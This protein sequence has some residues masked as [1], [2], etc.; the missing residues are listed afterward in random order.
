MKTKTKLIQAFNIQMLHL[1]R[2]NKQ[3]ILFYKWPRLNFNTKNY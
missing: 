1:N 2:N 3:K